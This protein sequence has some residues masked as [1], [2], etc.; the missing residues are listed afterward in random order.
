[1][2]P[3]IV[4]LVSS[5]GGLDAMRQILATLPR[6]FPAAI[7][8]LQHLEPARTS[9]LPELLAGHCSLPVSPVTDGATLPA[10]VVL[11]APAGWHTLVAPGPTVVLVR[12]A[13]GP[14]PSADLLLTSLAITCGPR[15]LAVVLSG[16]GYDGA[17]GI[18]VIKRFG[19]Q[20]LTSDEATSREFGMPS[21][22][23]ARDHVDNV[24]PVH[25]IGPALI[26]L[27]E[28]VPGS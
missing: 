8:A 9:Q 20:V 12:S 26:G 7:L 16:R 10:G 15:A 3:P 14:R 24:L 5:V 17:N 21:A 4:A 13:E 27:L 11:V 25:R 28:A 1:M 18:S 23:I 19:G 22:A 2:G 6:D